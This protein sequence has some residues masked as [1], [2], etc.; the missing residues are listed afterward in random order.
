[1]PMA[2]N[3]RKNFIKLTTAIYILKIL[4]QSGPSHGNKIAEEIRHRTNHVISPNPNSLYPT[5]H[6]MEERGYIEGAWDSPVTRS[7]RI[8]SIT[9]Y[10]ISYLPEME[11]KLKHRIREIEI[12]IRIIKEDLLTD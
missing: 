11:E 4:H 7:K 5:L 3:G 9:D 2:E 6:L 12:N 1:M 8:Y 10:G